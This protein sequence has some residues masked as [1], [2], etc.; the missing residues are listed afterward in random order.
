[1]KTL[2]NRPII[3]WALILLCL[4]LFGWG[5][6]QY[7]KKEEPVDMPLIALSSI[8]GI[9]D[10]KL[11]THRLIM[12]DAKYKLATQEEI[13][14]ALSNSLFFLSEVKKDCKAN[15]DADVFTMCQCYSRKV[16]SV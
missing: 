5:S 10:E 2:I 14:T 7:V 9:Y 13:N 15:T 6:L 4:V 12:L 3:R 16:F 1:M 8:P 11:L